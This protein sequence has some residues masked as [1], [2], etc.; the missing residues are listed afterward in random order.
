TVLNYVSDAYEW[1]VKDLGL[2]VAML[3]GNHDLETNDSVYSANAAAALKSIGVQIVC[4]RK[5][6]SIKLGDV[7]VH[8]VSWR[9]NL[10]EL[11]SDL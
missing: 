8:M 6:H 9:K 3:A 10:A 2:S 5:P 11:I 1:I 7:T 4:G